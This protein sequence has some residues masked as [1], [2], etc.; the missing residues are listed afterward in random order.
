MKFYLCEI[1]HNKGTLNIAVEANGVIGIATKFH[2]GPDDGSVF[3]FVHHLNYLYPVVTHKEI[4][5]PLLKYFLILPNFAFGVTRIVQE[6]LAEPILITPDIA[7]SKDQQFEKI[8][9]YT[10]LIIVNDETYYVYNLQ[11]IQVPKEASVLPTNTFSKKDSI[12][13]TEEKHGIENAEYLIIGNKYAVKKAKVKTIL[14]SEFVTPYKFH[15]FDGFIDYK[16]IIPVKE[17]DNGKFVVVLQNNAYKTNKISLTS[18]KVLIHENT[19]KQILE[20]EDGKYEI[21]D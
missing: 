7:V 3:G 20:T 13:A 8:A 21:I 6:I 4:T 16:N 5:N 2:P 19:G 1:K 10:G 18:G 11:N 15:D 12:K 14:K 9:E 17:L